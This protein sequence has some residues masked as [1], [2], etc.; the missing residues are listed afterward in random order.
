MF[1]CQVIE[2]GNHYNCKGLAKLY[3]QLYDFEEY[4]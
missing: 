4:P 3:I 2:Q 1:F